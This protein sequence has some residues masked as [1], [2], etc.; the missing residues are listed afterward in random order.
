MK[1]TIGKYTV[2]RLDEQNITVSYLKLVNKKEGGQV[3]QS[4]RLGYYGSIKGALNK[5][6]NHTIESSDAETCSDLISVISE[7]EKSITN[8]VSKDKK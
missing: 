2:E 6:F 8:A 3:E 7:A 1:I 4:V 5:V